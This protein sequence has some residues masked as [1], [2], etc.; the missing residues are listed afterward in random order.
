MPTVLYVGDGPQATRHAYD[1][2]NHQAT[3]ETEPWRVEVVPLGP[4][5]RATQEGLRSWLKGEIKEYPSQRSYAG[6]VV[7]YS[8]RDMVTVIRES[9]PT[10]PAIML[11]APEGA[12]I[13]GIDQLLDFFDINKLPKK[14]LELIAVRKA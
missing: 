3:P 10:T 13:D 9:H 7:D 8:W 14:M 4:F 2:F 6:I 1:W 11:L 5:D 12:K